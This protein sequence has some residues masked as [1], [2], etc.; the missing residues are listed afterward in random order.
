MGAL[1]A[2][3]RRLRE[4][5]VAVAADAAAERQHRE[6][7]RRA[8]RAEREA[9]AAA[10]A[11]QEGESRWLAAALD[12]D[13]LIGLA[14]R[15]RAIDPG[16]CDQRLPARLVAASM[17]EAITAAARAALGETPSLEPAQA[18]RVGVAGHLGADS[19]EARGP[20]RP[21][22]PSPGTARPSPS[23]SPQPDRL[24][25]PWPWAR[26]PAR[27]R[28]A[29]AAGHEPLGP[30]MPGGGGWGSTENPSR[31]C[32]PSRPA[33]GSGCLATGSRRLATGSCCPATGSCRDA[34][35]QGS[36]QQ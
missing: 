1:V 29:T 22:C 6:E 11:D 36:D 5:L 4:H 3:V 17:A 23:A 21:H 16:L 35:V 19:G 7:A 28:A 34:S 27:P 30:Q 32:C 31:G 10:E 20:L 18:V 9:R 12:D 2:R 25:E 14:E 26:A 13:A 24:K 15:C 33:L 8:E